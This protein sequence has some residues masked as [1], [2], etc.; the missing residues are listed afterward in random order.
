MTAFKPVFLWGMPGVGKST[1]G[2]RIA[3]QLD[4]QWID[5]DLFIEHKFNTT[6][7]DIVA[8]E[9]EAYFR[10]IEKNALVE[11]ADKKNTVISCGG[12]TPTYF[13]NSKL[14]SAS[15]LCI[16]LNADIK[17]ILTRIIQSKQK[18]FLF[19]DLEND[20]LFSAIEELFKMRKVYFERAEL[21]F[22]IPITHFSEEILRLKKHLKLA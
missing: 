16:Y 17:F 22:K 15:G 6:I 21:Q 7:S 3:K 20:A 19:K 1:L 18:R 8:K 14:M 13:D 2:K 12:G 9:G 11:I 5:L 4:W 10:E